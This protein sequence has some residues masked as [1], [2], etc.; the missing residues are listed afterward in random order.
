MDNDQIG[1]QWEED[2]SGEAGVPK[3]LQS[4][5]SGLPF[6][7]CLVCSMDLDEA[8]LH[9]VEKVIRNGEAVMEMALCATCA[10]NLSRDCSQESLAIL[11][12]V[13]EEW[14]GQADPK[15][16]YCAGCRKPRDHSDSFV[17]AG[18][19]LPDF[20]LVRR[21]AVCETCHESVQKKLSTKTRENFGTFVE[22]HF[23]GVPENID[24][25]V[26]LA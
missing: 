21:M 1:P 8:E 16:R 5:Y 15:G 4:T 13:Q 26:I 19:F 23:P 14:M 18:Y 12:D 2:S 24:S 9:I 3:I 22:T 25:P 6:Q 7:T 10:N 20:E 17:I 11:Q